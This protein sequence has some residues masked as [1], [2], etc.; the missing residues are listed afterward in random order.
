MARLKMMLRRPS[1]YLRFVAVSATVT[2]IH[3]IAKWL[4]GCCREF[5]STY[6]PVPLVPHV[7]SY[8]KGSMNGFVVSERRSK[9]TAEGL[10]LAS[11]RAKF[12]Q[13]SR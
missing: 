2:N 1:A 6:R 9:L 10:L 4:S 3:D 8:Y 13:T 5:D 12:G 11:V 7:L